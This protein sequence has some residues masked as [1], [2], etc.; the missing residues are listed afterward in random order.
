MRSEKVLEEHDMLTARRMLAAAAIFASAFLLFMVEPLFA[1][2]ILP[3]FGGSAAVWST[4]LVFYQTALLFGYLYARVLSR[5]A[6]AF[7]QAAVHIALLLLSLW[8]LPIGPSDKWQP[9][10]GTPPTGAILL[11]LAATL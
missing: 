6:N 10:P 8:M 2:R 3:W 11:M 5:Y 9:A 7:T 4:C 1:K